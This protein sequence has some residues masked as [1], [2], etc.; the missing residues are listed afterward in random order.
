MVTAVTFYLF[1]KK[2]RFYFGN[3]KINGKNKD[4]KD[5]FHGTISKLAVNLIRYQEQLK[6]VNTFFLYQNA[7]IHIK[8]ISCHFIKC[9]QFF[10]K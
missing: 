4:T 2:M 10:F 7:T 3:R 5:Q 9:L 1:E 8:H 6:Y